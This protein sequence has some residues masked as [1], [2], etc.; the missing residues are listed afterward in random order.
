MD[1][2]QMSQVNLHC[3]N[4]FNILTV[5][6]FH[7]LSFCYGYKTYQSLDLDQQNQISPRPLVVCVCFDITQNSHC[8]CLFMYVSNDR[9][10]ACQRGR[11]EIWFLSI[12][13]DQDQCIIPCSNVVG[14]TL[15]IACTYND[16]S[17]VCMMLPM[18]IWI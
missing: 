6:L 18:L 15:F 17:H 9:R 11:E 5:S 14:C 12:I 4:F 2:G 16:V 10:R 8:I 1:V 7:L 13:L 3:G